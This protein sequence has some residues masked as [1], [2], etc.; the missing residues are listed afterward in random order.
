MERILLT[1]V[2]ITTVQ[3]AMD[4]QNTENHYKLKYVRKQKKNNHQTGE[5][6]RKVK[7]VK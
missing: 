2:I 6:R 1:L 7:V 4:E 3:S 5:A